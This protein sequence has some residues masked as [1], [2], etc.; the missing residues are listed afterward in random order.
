[1]THVVLLTVAKFTGKPDARFFYHEDGNDNFLRNAGNH[2]QD[3]TASKAR[4]PQPK[5]FTS[6]KTS[7]VTISSHI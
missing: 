2:L 1:M 5:I 7:N 3:Y 4:R 6:V